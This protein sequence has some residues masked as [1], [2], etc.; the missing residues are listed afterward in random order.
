MFM[1][2]YSEALQKPKTREKRIAAINSV[3]MA[4]PTGED[5]RWSGKK[6]DRNIDDNLLDLLESW[7]SACNYLSTPIDPEDFD[8]EERE[9]VLQFLY[10][11]R[12]TLWFAGFIR[13]LTTAEHHLTSKLDEAENR[14]ANASFQTERAKINEE[15]L[16]LRKQ[17]NDL[18]C[19]VEAMMIN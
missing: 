12:K 5:Y 9:E 10:Q 15:I 19:Q 18:I 11:T 7:I 1:K 13:R 2:S 16:A 6:I 8:P 3:L 14:L 17:L 4:T